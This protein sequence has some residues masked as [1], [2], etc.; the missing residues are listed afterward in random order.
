VSDLPDELRRALVGDD[1]QLSMAELMER[2][3]AELHALARRAMSGERRAHTL[4]PTALVH[5]AFLRLVDSRNASAQGRLGFLRAAAVTMRRVLVD[6]ARA[7]GTDKRGGD[8]ARV[9]LQGLDVEDASEITE[10]IDLIQL[11]AV[12]QQ[13]ESLDPRQARMVELR[14]FG[15]LTGREIAE[16]T[17]VS[18]QTVVREL[19]MARAWMRHRLDST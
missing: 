19:T 9:T 15:G 5:E 14:F 17:G 2:V 10:E 16:V 7:R 6:H 1:E 13:L 11:D 18:R 3:Y 8:W 12:L 4:Q